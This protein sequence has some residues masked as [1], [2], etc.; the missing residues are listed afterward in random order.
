M[1]INELQQ[2]LFLEVKNKLP[3]EAS[4]ADEIAKLL[5]KSTDS[6][7]RRLRGEKTIS[8]EELF[9]LCTHYNISLDQMMNIHSEAYPF[10]GKMVGSANFS[11]N[12][13]ITSL[14]QYLVFITSFKNHAIYY[15]CKDIPI[16]YQFQFREIAAFKYYFWMKTLLRFPEFTGRQ[17]SFDIYPDETFEMEKKA[18]DLYTQAS[19]NEIWNVESITV[20]LRQIEFYRESRMFKS[21]KDVFRIYE[22]FEK[23]ID[24][25][26]K[27]ASLGYRFEYG[28]PEMKPKGG[29]NMYFN[30][31]IIGDNSQLAVFG[32][33]K[34]AFISHSIFNF[35]VTRDMRFCDYVSSNIK[36]LME[37]STLISGVSERERGRFFR[38]MREKIVRRKNTLNV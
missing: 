29:F 9:I 26:E 8:F 4:V 20:H 5:D 33:Y 34:M 3:A 23:L 6:M 22:A 16:F 10:L 7:Y 18:L 38:I 32:E 2:K 27:Q 13:Y 25:I 37:R 31:V 24:H 11:F 28:D 36:S 35:M 17:F 19:T 21:D 15:L 1:N 30:E 12:E 14:I